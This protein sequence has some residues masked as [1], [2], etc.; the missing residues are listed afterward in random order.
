MATYPLPSDGVYTFDPP[1]N[2][3]NHSLSLSGT[4]GTVTLEARPE[5]DDSWHAVPNG[6]VDMTAPHVVRFVG[7]VDEY[8]FTLSGASAPVTVTEH[9]IPAGQ[10]V[11]Y[12]AVETTFEPL[13]RSGPSDFRRLRVDAGEP[14]FW[15]AQQFAWQVELNL[16]A[17][18][19]Q[20]FRFDLVT[21][22]ILL[23]SQ[24]TVDS[25]SL[26]YRVFRADQVTETGTFATDVSTRAHALNVT[27]FA[28]AYT[29][30]TTAF[31]DGV[32]AS[33]GITIDGGAIAYPLA[34]VRTSGATAQAFLVG[35]SGGLARGFPP[36]S[37]YVVA[38]Q[39]PGA[40]GGTQGT[41]TLKFEE[42][43]WGY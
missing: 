38:T 32:S 31:T 15:A 2:G 7:S 27:S 41:I 22:V 28:P 33:G 11:N 1:F 10:G 40:S 30:Q 43:T 6:T 29:R 35:A 21:D 24:I 36:T 5:G 13:L 25:G 39:L 16:A 4:D 20:V 17:G 8:R 34:R 18:E 12:E 23:D 26:Y 37:A 19:T 42:R 14:G 3:H 9:N